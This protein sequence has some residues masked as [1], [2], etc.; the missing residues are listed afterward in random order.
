MLV[1][2]LDF[3][4]INYIFSLDTHNLILYMG[5]ELQLLH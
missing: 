5:L 1:W 2:D 3:Q 4:I